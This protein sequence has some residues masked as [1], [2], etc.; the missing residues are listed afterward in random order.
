MVDAELDGLTSGGQTAIDMAPT[1][2]AYGA[3]Q[4]RFRELGVVSRAPSAAALLVC[5][6][7][8]PLP[9]PPRASVRARLPCRRL[10][11]AAGQLRARTRA[12]RTL[13]STGF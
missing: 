11:G 2:H 8:Q 1:A 3:G 4:A 12:R 13:T 9:G 7:L 10:A 6:C 5:A